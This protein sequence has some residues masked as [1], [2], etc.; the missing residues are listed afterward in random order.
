MRW[1]QVLKFLTTKT[2]QNKTRPK[3]GLKAVEQRNLWQYLTK[4]IARTNEWQPNDLNFGKRISS[5]PILRKH[6]FFLFMTFQNK[7]LLQLERRIRM[8]EATAGKIQW[9]QQNPCRKI[10][11]GISCLIAWNWE[12]V[13]WKEFIEK[14][15]C[16]NNKKVQHFPFLFMWPKIGA[17]RMLTMRPNVSSSSF[18]LLVV[19]IEFPGYSC[20]NCLELAKG[21]IGLRHVLDWM[22]RL[23]A[24]WRAHI[25]VPLWKA[26]HKKEKKKRIE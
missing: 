5:H 6:I 12:K 8:V 9:E 1:F 26:A 10:K 15:V 21:N 18:F 24:A 13:K 7:F 16:G 3:N 2:K 19:T 25:L 22:R 14:E 23:C 20:W 4:R 17:Q 11:R